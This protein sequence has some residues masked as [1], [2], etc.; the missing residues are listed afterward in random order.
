MCPHIARN[1]L[2]QNFTSR[3]SLYT[4]SNLSLQMLLQVDFS[5]YIGRNLSLQ[6]ATTFPLFKL[7]FSVANVVADAYGTL[8]NRQYELYQYLDIEEPSSGLCELC[9]ASDCRMNKYMRNK[10]STFVVI[11]STVDWLTDWT[12]H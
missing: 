6:N 2:L 9:Y 1:L 8:R 11:F 3:F 5:P 12:D 7:T 10:R 4:G